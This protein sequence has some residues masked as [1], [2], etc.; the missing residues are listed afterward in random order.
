[1]ILSFFQKYAVLQF[2]IFSILA[3]TGG[4]LMSQTF[5]LTKDTQSFQLS[6]GIPV[7]F[8]NAKDE[9][10]PSEEVVALHITSYGGVMLT[11]KPGAL[12]LLASLMT[13]GTY[14]YSKEKI[15]EL[16]TRTGSSLSVE[17]G[18][19]SIDISVR[20]LR[21]FLPE[22]LSLVSELMRVPLLEEKELKLLM[23]Q[24][25]ASL[26]SEQD[27]ADSLMGLE[28][29]K[30]F[31]AGH[32]YLNRPSGFRDS[33]Q[34]VKREDLHSL[35]FR[36][37]NRQNILVT[38]VGQMNRSEIEPLLNQSF[39]G[40]PE[41]KRTS[42][43]Q[44]APQN[45]FSQLHF[46]EFPA[47]ATTYFLTRFKA[48]S[49]EHPDYPSLMIGMRILSNR[50]FD[51]VRTKRA[52]GYSVAARLGGGKVGHGSLF[53]F[54]TDLVQAVDVMFNEVNRMKEAL[55]L[56]K[57]IDDQI[58]QYLSSW[59]MGRETRD[60]QAA[61][62]A[63]YELMGVGWENSGSFIHRL[64]RVSQSS[65]QEAMKKYLR[66]MSVVVVGKEKPEIELA[67]RNFGALQAAQ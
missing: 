4:P 13:K 45:D 36:A 27:Q 44:Q 48:P 50:L 54:S 59:Y 12:D 29:L 2:S 56:Q 58:H 66:D 62:F 38:I 24:Q 14:S 60:S 10:G 21:R 3:A 39:S 55:V 65:V 46:R 40:L 33:I 61:I 67:L 19:D 22:L 7:I 17:A 43:T 57:D 20:C 34:E 26:K 32:P 64:R 6:S 1:M 35:L 42:P 11:D 49:L 5:D 16:M 25:L 52:L 30:V 15:D 28:M 63:H 47:A 31:Y 23:D 37:F 9:T 51:E 18:N 53:V 8:R 41:G